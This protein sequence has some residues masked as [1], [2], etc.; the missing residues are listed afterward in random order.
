MVPVSNDPR[1]SVRERELYG[2]NQDQEGHAVLAVETI[3]AGGGHYAVPAGGVR[4]RK[5]D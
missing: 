2:R 5:R 1:L 4:Y 3:G